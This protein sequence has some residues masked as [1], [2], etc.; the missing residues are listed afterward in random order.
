VDH[1]TIQNDLLA[2][3]SPKSGE[4]VATG[5]AGGDEE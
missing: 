4:K 5:S 3:K 2:N 1:K